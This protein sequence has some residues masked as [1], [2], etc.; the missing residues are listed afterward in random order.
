MYETTWICK[1]QTSVK[2]E[3]HILVTN[4]NQM[5]NN[6]INSTNSRKT[7]IKIDMTNIKML[8]FYANMST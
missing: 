6:M 1:Y 5:K 7:D 4:Q 8:S 3:K 2:E